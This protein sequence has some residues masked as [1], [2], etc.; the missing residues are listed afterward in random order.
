MP[1]VRE[2]R[3]RTLFVAM[4]E[5]ARTSEGSGLWVPKGFLTFWGSGA[6][7]FGALGLGFGEG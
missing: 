2:R 4:V 7:S 6:S 3:A 5:P 1:E